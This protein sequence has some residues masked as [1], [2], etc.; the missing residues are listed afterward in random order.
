MLVSNEV[1]INNFN[2]FIDFDQYIEHL[3]S[4]AN[5]K[6][7]QNFERIKRLATLLFMHNYNN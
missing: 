7:D 2:Q 6:L 4:L 3:V 5:E 1:I